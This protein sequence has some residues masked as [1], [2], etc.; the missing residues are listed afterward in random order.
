MFTLDAAKRRQLPAWIREGLEKMEKEKQKAVERERQEILR[1]QELEARKQAEDEARAVLNPCK[2]KFVGVRMHALIAC[3]ANK[4]TLNVRKKHRC[5]I[6][7]CSFETQDSDSEKET[8]QDDE[9]VRSQQVTEKNFERTPDILL[10][11]RKSRFRDADSPDAHTHTDRS[12]TTSNA[13]ITIPKRTREEI[14]Q[15]VV[16]I[17]SIESIDNRSL[18]SYITDFLRCRC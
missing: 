17:I 1:K 5:V 14:L 9:G 10:R 12:P 4:A 13:T 11:P 15:D 7:R 8:E 18:I 16:N 6:R 3:F 2:S